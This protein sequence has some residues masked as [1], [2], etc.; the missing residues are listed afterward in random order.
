MLLNASVQA[1]DHLTYAFVEAEDPD[2][3]SC[4]IRHR[5]LAVEL[6]RRLL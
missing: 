3:Q 4:P 1:I 2:R 6:R 5:H